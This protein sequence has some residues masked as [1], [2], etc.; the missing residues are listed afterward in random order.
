MPADH[1]SANGGGDVVIAGSDVGDEGAED[2]ERRST[3]ELDFLV[4][5]LLD[6]VHGN[7][8]RAF[9]HDLNVVLPG[10]A[11]ELAESLQFGKL[12]FVGGVRNRARTEAVAK[13]V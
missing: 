10:L 3:A 1:R 13:R 12:R 9:D 2:V 6:L 7:V 4:D 5:L 8:A 11:G